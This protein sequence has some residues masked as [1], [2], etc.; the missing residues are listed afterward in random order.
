MGNLL[1]NGWKYT[2][3]KEE[4]LIEFG[5]VE[6]KGKPAYY[7]R[8]NGVGFDM[9]DVHN[10]FKAFQRLHT[11]QKF[12]GLNIGLS[13]VQKIVQRHGGEVW[14]EGSVGRGATFYFTLE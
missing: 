3:E 12:E 14:A 4:A 7:V 8:D 11:R 5:L 2:S 9:S 6:C 1:G 10:F 13:V